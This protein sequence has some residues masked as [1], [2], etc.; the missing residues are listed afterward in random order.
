[1]VKAYTTRVGEGPFPTEFEPE[2][3]DQ[4][5][6]K[7]AEFGATTGRARRCGWFDAVLAKTSVDINGIDSVVITKL[8]VLDDLKEIQIS[9]AYEYQGKRY[10]NIPGIPGFLDKCKPVYEVLPG[11]QCDTSEVTSSEDLPGNA[12]KYIQ[13]IRELMDCDIALISVGKSRGQTM[14]YISK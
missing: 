6:K 1:M 11:W 9:T 12:K 7:G 2:F 8:D 3:D 10:M 4:I 14:E 13:R 5:R